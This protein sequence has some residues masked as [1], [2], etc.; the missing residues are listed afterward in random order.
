MENNSNEKDKQNKKTVVCNTSLLTKIFIFVFLL[1]AF[2]PWFILPL[3]A[4]SGNDIITFVQALI[5]P[6]AIFYFIYRD[7]CK[8][9]TNK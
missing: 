9:N 1:I 7:Y 8:K 5:F 4:F 3:A 2:A 6:L